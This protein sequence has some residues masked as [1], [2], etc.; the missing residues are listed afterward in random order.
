LERH[1]CLALLTII[2]DHHRSSLIDSQTNQQ[3]ASKHHRHTMSGLQSAYGYKERRRE[4]HTQAE[5]KRRDAIKKGYEDLQHMVPTCQQQDSISS[6]KLSKATIL[7]RS[8]EY[9]QNLHKSKLKHDNELK[10]L[11]KEVHALQIMK[12]NYEQMLKQHQITALQLNHQQVNQASEQVKFEIFQAFCDN[13]FV[14]FD[15]YVTC[16]D[17]RQLSASILGWLEENGKPQTLRD[18]CLAILRDFYTP[19]PNPVN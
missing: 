14:S 5:Q 10:T 8:I 4:A 3:A 17:F 6:Y 13:L 16:G 18:M 19:S 12:A 11:R 2:T 7:Q 1:S 15:R 9:I